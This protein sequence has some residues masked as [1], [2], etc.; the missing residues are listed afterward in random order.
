MDDIAE[1]FWLGCAGPLV[2]LVAVVTGVVV[3]LECEKLIVGKEGG[4][5]MGRMFSEDGRWVEGR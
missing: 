5:E 3:L 4:G 2:T 1:G